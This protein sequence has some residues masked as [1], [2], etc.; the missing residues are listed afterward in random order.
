M[1]PKKFVPTLV[2]QIVAHWAAAAEDT[3]PVTVVLYP[4][5]VALE[6]K[7]HVCRV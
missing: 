3:V 1:R 7:P 6:S 5:L 4:Q 2:M